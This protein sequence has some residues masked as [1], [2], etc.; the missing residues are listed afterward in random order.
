MTK[1]IWTLLKFVF[2]VGL[3]WM[4]LQNAWAEVDKGGVELRSTLFDIN[5]S[6]FAMAVVLNGFSFVG[7]AF[8]WHKLLV[9]QG[10]SISWATSFKN[11]FVGLFFNHF[12]L[13]NAGG[14]VQKVVDLH[15][16]KNQWKEALVATLFDRI[17]GL[18][19]INGFALIVGWVYFFNHDKLQ[20]LIWPS[21]WIALCLSI[22]FAILFSKRLSRLLLKLLGFFSFLGPVADKLGIVFERFVNYRK[23]HLVLKLLGFS[24][25]I[26]FVRIYVHYLVG[27]SIGVE[28]D[29]IYYLYFIPMIGI[30][31]ALPISF[32]GFGPREYI[33]QALFML[34]AVNAGDAIL[35][36]VLA[37]MCA[38][39]P[40]LI[41]G[42]IF[43]K[44]K[45]ALKEKIRSE[46][47]IETA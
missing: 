16:Q 29:L 18:F 39:I 23:N 37:L 47:K 38:F 31:S 40:S 19:I 35:I 9:Y 20:I 7:S 33:A 41:G 17:F 13:G 27:L 1:H 6:I 10:I 3:I 26:Q 4:V 14:D 22:F 8:Q 42:W 21:T 5:L 45:G 44:R 2:S 12:L 46:S 43:F 15:R 36:Q 11:Y 32:A 30:V 25:G 28:I 24:L 34:V